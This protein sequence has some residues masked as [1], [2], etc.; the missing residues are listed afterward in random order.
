MKTE[1][2]F[3]FLSH[4]LPSVCY[5]TDSAEGASGVT[6]AEEARD[7]SKSDNGPSGLLISREQ[8]RG[9]EGRGGSHAML[10]IQEEC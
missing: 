10:I 4:L 5:Y 1:T 7:T 2:G 8:G 3:C 9:G 6:P